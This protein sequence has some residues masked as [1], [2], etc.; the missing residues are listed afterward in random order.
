MLLIQIALPDSRATTQRTALKPGM[1]ACVRSTAL[2][3]VISAARARCQCPSA[4]CAA[5][6]CRCDGDHSG[7]HHGVC[8]RRRALLQP[9]PPRAPLAAAAAAPCPGAPPP[10]AA[11]AAGRFFEACVVSCSYVQ[12]VRK[13]SLLSSNSS[14]V[15]HM[16]I[17]S[18]ATATSHC[19]AASGATLRGLQH[20]AACGVALLCALWWRA[21]SSNKHAAKW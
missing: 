7:G 3:S 4:N 5:C 13:K 6:L 16:Y 10:C 9:L 14:P 8:P 12:L 18:C 17:A 21:C 20:A 19:A 11:P 2:P 1:L 15:L